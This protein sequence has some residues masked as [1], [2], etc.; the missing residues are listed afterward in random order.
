MKGNAN[1][2]SVEPGADADVELWRCVSQ[3]WAMSAVKLSNC[4]LHCLSTILHP[5]GCGVQLPMSALKWIVKLGAD[6]FRAT[7]AANGKWHKAKVTPMQAAK[8]RK[9][10]LLEGKYVHDVYACVAT[11]CRAYT[12]TAC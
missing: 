7:K 4:K 10:F 2:W 3:V 5:R 9:Q 1:D 8:L 6:A 11:I 12:S